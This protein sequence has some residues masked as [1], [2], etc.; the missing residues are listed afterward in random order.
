MGFDEMLPR[1]LD[2][3]DDETNAENRNQDIQIL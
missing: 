2:V 1:H 3:T